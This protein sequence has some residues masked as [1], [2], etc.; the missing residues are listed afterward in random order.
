MSSPVPVYVILSRVHTNQ[1][2]DDLQTTVPGW[3]IKAR[4]SNTGTVLPV[5]VPDSVYTP[6]TVD[7]LIRAAGAND[8]QI[9]KLG[10]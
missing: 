4:W 7:A 3:S 8:E 5:F 6:Q 9:H 2:D 1:W 10:R